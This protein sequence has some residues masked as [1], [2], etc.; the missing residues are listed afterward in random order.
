MGYAPKFRR[1]KAELDGAFPRELDITGEGTASVTGYFEVQIVGG[2][3]LH[4]KK[5]GNGYVDT[6]E[7][8]NRIVQGIKDALAAAC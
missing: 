1:I 8:M 7:K 3:L 4:S 6:P 5:N 2:K